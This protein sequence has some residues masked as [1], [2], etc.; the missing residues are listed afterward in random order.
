MITHTTKLL[1]WTGRKAQQKDVLLLGYR[2]LACIIL[3]F[4]AAHELSTCQRN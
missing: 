1:G 3:V 2:F 4:P